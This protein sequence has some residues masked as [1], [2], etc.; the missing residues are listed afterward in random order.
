MSETSLVKKDLLSQLLYEAEAYRKFEDIER[1]V[2]GGLDLSVLPIQPLYVALQTTS[3]DQIAQILPK[4]SGEQRQALR[5]I[6]LWDKDELDTKA[7]MH[8]LEIYSK[9]PSD[10]VKFE[11]ARSEDFLL[12]VKNQM[13]VQTFDVEDPLYPDNDNYFLTEDNLLLI[14]Y[15]EDFTLVQ[16]LKDMVK[17]LYSGM[18]VEYAYT[19]LFKMIVDSYQIMEE[20]NYN[21]KVERLRDFGFVDH[22]Q[23]L[24]YDA[25][26]FQ[27]EQLD[28]FIQNKK[29]ATGT[30]SSTASF[31]SLHASSLTSYQAGMDKIKEALAKVQ[32]EKRQQYLHFNFIRLVNAQMTLRGALKG[33][34][35]AMAKVGN[36]AKQNLD[37][38]FDYVLSKLS[39]EEGEQIFSRFDFLDLFKIGQSLI[40]ISKKKVKV[41]LSKTPFDSH[42]LSYFL[43]MYWNSLLENSE[44]E[45]AKFK[46]DGSSKASEIDNLEVYRLWNSSLDT[47]I[48]AFPYVQMFF[49]SLEKLKADNLLNDEFYLNYEVDNIDFEAIMIS[50]LIN[51]VGEHYQENVAGKMGIT[52]SE[53]K[54]FYHKYFNKNGNEYLIKGEE[55]LIL[56][57]KISLFVEK[58]G[59]ALIPHFDKY[60][61]QILLEQMNGYEIDSMDT[62]E[63]RHI[64][65]P[66]LLNSK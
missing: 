34:S 4:L 37:L 33:G 47:L 32:D 23:A 57:E 15:P 5:D 66:I 29:T 39:K 31:Q 11:Y 35:V 17:L 55:D 53:L 54:D 45:T 7:A 48:S 12:S 1:L 13:T 64:G 41:A 42:D 58:F 30:I 59:L 40:E 52:I 56:R 24:E 22:F 10:D 49:K 36:R 50:S 6:D 60:L 62:E 51:F 61:Y 8:W 14:E 27:L 43:G 3:S 44:E 46:F 20:N 21:E 38:G 28:N 65:G 19:F 2:E 9:C 16:E 63:F 26:F 25:P 18:G